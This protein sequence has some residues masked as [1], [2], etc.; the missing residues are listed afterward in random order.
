MSTQMQITDNDDRPEYKSPPSDLSDTPM[1]N[2]EIHN[3]A[4]NHNDSIA[5]ADDAKQGP[6]VDNN[7][8]ANVSHLNESTAKDAMLASLKLI[9]LRSTKNSSGNIN[10]LKATRTVPARPKHSRSISTA[11]LFANAF[12]FFEDMEEHTSPM[13]NDDDSSNF[14]KNSFQQPHD[15]F[16]CDNS[17]NKYKFLQGIASGQYVSYTSLLSILVY[18]TFSLILFAVFGCLNVYV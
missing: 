17:C 10:N 12:E 4:I 2:E 13:N 9:I 11:D 7:T 16:S 18:A 6:G 14:Q 15:T 5:S 8:S 3:D 1:P